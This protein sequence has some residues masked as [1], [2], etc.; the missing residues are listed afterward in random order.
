MKAAV[1]TEHGPP[2]SIAIDNHFPDPEP[3]PDDVVLRVGATSLNYHDIFT[4]NG[5][6]GI[7]VPM[8]MIMGL[9]LSGTI[10]EVGSNSK[11]INKPLPSDDPTRRKPNISLAQEKLGWE[12]KIALEDGSVHLASP[13]YRRRSARQHQPLAWTA[14]TA[15]DH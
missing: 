5:M 14:G 4:R 2:G 9:D 15:A 3:G 11:I 13:R 8:P 10:A 6:P 1:I 12:P 7:K